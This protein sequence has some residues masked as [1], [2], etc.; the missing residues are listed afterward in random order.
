[1]SRFVFVVCLCL[2]AACQTPLPK[3][4][5]LRDRQVQTLRSLGFVEEGDGWLMNIAEPIS[6]D[7]NQSEL[8]TSLRS[9]L[10]RIAKELLAADI[11]ALRIEGHTDNVGTRAYNETLSLRRAQAVAAEFIAAGF[12]EKD[13][14]YRGLAWDFPIASNATREGRAG[15]RR[16]SVIVPAENMAP[17]S[18]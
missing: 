15:N 10:V 4:S 18:D 14:A 8:R 17:A 13:I 7:S 5:S 11:R 9:S 6:F 16:V 2:L 1:M 3:Q 12:G